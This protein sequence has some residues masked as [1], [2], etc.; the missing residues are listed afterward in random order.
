MKL[1]LDRRFGVMV[2]VFAALAGTRKDRGDQAS[3][4]GGFAGLI[5]GL[6]SQLILRAVF[7]L[8]LTPIGALQ[9]MIGGRAMHRKIEPEAKSYWIP[10]QPPG[11]S[12]GSF[13]NEF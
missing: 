9:R 2:R 3:S 11:A 4:W 1:P 12:S 6:F 7:Y 10:R 8:V 13:R 5:H